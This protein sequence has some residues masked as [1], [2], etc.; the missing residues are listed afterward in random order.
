MTKIELLDKIKRLE[1]INKKLD[2]VMEGVVY[3][4]IPNYQITFR[5]KT[6][7]GDTFES[8]FIPFGTPKT[9]IKFIG[10]EIEENQDR[11]FEEHI[12]RRH[13]AVLHFLH[14]TAH[15]GDDISLAL[16]AEET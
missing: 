4:T 2:E 15:S 9:I 16:L 8:D 14:I 3:G 13:D 7:S 1:M 12:E 5:G 11:I 10:D 6:R